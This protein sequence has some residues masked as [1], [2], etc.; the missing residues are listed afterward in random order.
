MSGSIAVDSTITID[1]ALAIALIQTTNNLWLD[2]LAIHYINDG[3]DTGVSAVVGQGGIKIDSSV[4]FDAIT[5]GNNNVYNDN[6]N[7]GDL[8]S[9]LDNIGQTID[10]HAE[11]ASDMDNDGVIN[12]S[13]LYDVLDGI[14]QAPQT[15]DLVDTNGNLVTSLDA[16]STSVANWTII[17][18][19]DANASGMFEDVYTIASDLV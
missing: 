16:N 10:T 5:L 14:G 7:I 1:N 18:N 9:V 2:N 17:A 19:G 4:S 3:V 6:L 15:F 8:Y 13:D 11:H 12:I